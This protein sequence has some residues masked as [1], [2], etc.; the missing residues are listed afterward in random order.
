MD[1]SIL[2]LGRHEGWLRYVAHGVKDGDEQCI[3]RAAKLFDIMLPNECIVVPMPSH[4]GRATTLASV[5]IRTIGNSDRSYMDILRCAEHESS[6]S[7]KRD[8]F[9]P[10]DYE[11]W[12]DIV[13]GRTLDAPVFVLDNVVCSGATATAAIRAFRSRGIDARVLALTRAM[14]RS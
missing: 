2:W 11:M 9:E 10:E 1:G 6:Y 8:G 7:V 3:E 5:C 14:W 13:D 4:M 12:L